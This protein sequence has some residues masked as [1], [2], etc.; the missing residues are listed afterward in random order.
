MCCR[1]HSAGEQV[2]PSA[3][4]AERRFPVWIL[5]TCALQFRSL[6]A[7]LL[8][9]RDSFLVPGSFVYVAL[10]VPMQS[11]P[12]IPVAALLQ[13]GGT[14]QVAIV[15][16]DSTVRF[17]PVRVVSTD[18]ILINIGDNGV[19]A[20]EKIGLNVSNDVTEGARVRVAGR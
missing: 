13:R 19:K 3:G 12:Q 20:G 9:N 5:P 17:R 11:Y 16:E 7:L 1:R 14:Q 6:R 2:S 4:P 8:D 18:G 10:K 15:G